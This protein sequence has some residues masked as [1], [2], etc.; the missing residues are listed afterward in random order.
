MA[1]KIARYRD[2]R[3]QI[4]LDLSDFLKRKAIP[5]TMSRNKKASMATRIGEAIRIII[6]GGNPN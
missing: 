1:K 5:S 6:H 3:R 4:F 2:I